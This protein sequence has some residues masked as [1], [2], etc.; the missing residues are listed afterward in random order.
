MPGTKFC[1][2][3][4]ITYPDVVY[5]VQSR[6]CRNFHPDQGCT[7][8]IQPGKNS[9]S[10]L[11]L[12]IME[13]W[14]KCSANFCNPDGHPCPRDKNRQFFFFK[15]KRENYS[16]KKCAHISWQTRDI[17]TKHFSLFLWKWCNFSIFESFVL[18][19]L[20]YD[21]MILDGRAVKLVWLENKVG[22]SF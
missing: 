22:L 12:E 13:L 10:Y 18:Y 2:L 5:K 19:F 6:Y 3:Q 11:W 1:T 14:I 21:F 8:R 15:E 16:W 17:G 7:K 20:L 9:L 4:F